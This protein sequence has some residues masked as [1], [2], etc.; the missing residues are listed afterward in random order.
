[1]SVASSAH[2]WP[3]P[4]SYPTSLCWDRTDTLHTHHTH[5]LTTSLIWWLMQMVARQSEVAYWLVEI[6]L[7]CENC[8]QYITF[9]VFTVERN[10]WPHKAYKM[11]FSSKL[12]AK[13][14][15]HNP[16]ENIKRYVMYTTWYN[17]TT[18]KLALGPLQTDQQIILSFQDAQKACAWSLPGKKAVCYTKMSHNVSISALIIKN[19]KAHW[20]SRIPKITNG[21]FHIMCISWCALICTHLRYM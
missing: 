14:T 18:T 2:K 10:K 12:Q 7:S 4:L 21:C 1:M 16:Q 6:S 11:L 19:Y 13:A 3:Q 9:Y 8:L 20:V 17:H 15:G 5:Q